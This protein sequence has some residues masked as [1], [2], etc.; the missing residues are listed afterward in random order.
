MKRTQLVALSAIIAAGASA[1]TVTS[2]DITDA[3]ESGFGGWGHTYGGTITNTGSGT[4]NSFAFDRADYT[5]GSGTL[6]DGNN[7]TGT[8]DTQLFANNAQADPHIT[9][10]LDGSYTVDDITLFSFDGGNSIPG[11]ISGC[12]VTINGVTVPFATSEPST[13]DEF[14]DLSGSPLAG[15]ATTQITLSN[16]TH[17]GGNGLDEMFSIAEITVSGSPASI[18]STYDIL[19]A[20]ESGF[21]GWSHLYNGTITNTGSGTANGFAFD[22]AD[23]S[24]GGGTLNDGLPGTGTGDTQLFANNNQANP[25]IRVNL[26]GD[27]CVQGLTL[28]SFDAG[29]SIPGTISG[30]DVTINGVT[31]SVTTSEVTAHNELIDLGNTALGGMV[32]DSF[33]LSN[34]THDG[35]NGL[36][37]MFSIG[38]IG[39]TAAPAATIVDYDI[40]DAAESGFGG[41]SHVYNGTITNTGSGTANGFAFDRADYA[42]GGGTLNDGNPGTGAADTQLF[43]NNAQANPRIRVNLDGAH[44]IHGVTLYSFDSG[45]SIPGTIRGLDVTINGVTRTFATSEPTEDDE[46]IDLTGSALQNME[47]NAVTF[48]NF[49]HDGTNGLDEMFSIAEILV[50][51][52]PVD[53][54]PADLDGD[55]DTDADDFFAYLDAFANGNLAVCDIDNDGD[56][57]ADDFFGYLDQFA[58]GC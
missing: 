50:H 27:Y 4:A 32:T 44:T 40:A 58:Q 14:I 24:G 26:N 57:D 42:D 5:G 38:E 23:Y 8:G 29:N 48:S 19:D 3:A 25:R 15:L 1:Q 21:G 16:F 43:A 11:R 31:V 41:W 9:I 22:R 17:D 49:L 28:F 2:Y 13:N 54:C 30:C 53:D 10:Y 6:N 20:A 39:V 55:G 51:G 7:G 46:F 34:F 37:E 45:N 18:I 56:C 33:V 12:D 52:T 36:D 35:S 47:S